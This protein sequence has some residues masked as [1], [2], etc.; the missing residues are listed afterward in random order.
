MNSNSGLQQCLYK[1]LDQYS[2]NSMGS[3]AK[4]RL[5]T[6]FAKWYNLV[7]LTSLALLATLV[8]VADIFGVYNTETSIV[9]IARLLITIVT[10]VLAIT[11]IA[12]QKPWGKWLAMITYGIFVFPAIAGLIS[13]FYAQSGFSLLVSQNAIL[14]LRI[15]RLALI[16]LSS[17][18]VIA[19][20]QKPKR[21][22]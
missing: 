6:P 10:A 7:Y 11:G 19:L 14:M 3:N 18:G 12:L 8:L 4:P 17:I 13:S 15:Q 21:D 2:S 22:S 16:I 9:Q 5:Y 20:L 1:K